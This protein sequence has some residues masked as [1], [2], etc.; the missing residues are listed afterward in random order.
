MSLS[1]E[2][3]IE[4]SEQY[5]FHK[6]SLNK[7]EQNPWVK[8][9]WPLVYFI[10][11]ESKRIAYVGESTNASSRIKNHLANPKK[12]TVF[13]KIS[14][15][16]SD[17]FNKSA[18]LDIESN[19][20]QYITSEGTYELQNGNYGLINHNYY[21]QD[22]YKDLFKEIWNK[23]I[24]KKIVSKSLTEIENSELFKYSPYKSLN[25]DQYKSV[26]EILEGL[27][28]KKTNR[29]FIKGSAGTGKTILAT[30]LIKLLSTD[31]SDTN[32]EEFN[33]NELKEI[34]Y[35][36]AF[37]EKYPKAKIGLVIAMT[38]LRK[39]LENVFRKIPGL[40]PSMVINPSDTFKLKEKYD[41]LIVD[42]AHR[43]RQ[44]KN[45]GWLGAF[46]KN[47]QK[48]GLDNTGN[49]LDWIMA[50]SK[51][52]IFFYDAAQ[53]VKPSDIDEDNFTQLLD[54]NNTLS[55]QLISQM[56]VKGGNDFISFVDE[57][58]H[59]RRSSKVLYNPK[60]YELLIFD[61][62]KDLYEEL[63][64]REEKYGLCRLIAGYS[65][66]WL[67]DPKRKPKPNLDAIDIEIDGLKF[68]W[69]KTNEDW[70]NSPNAFKQVGC[71]HT[72]QGYDLNYA[73]II[74]G[75][76][77]TFNKK[78]NSIEINPDL[79]FDKNGKRGITDIEDLKSYIINIY[80]TIMY[81]GIKGVFIYACNP[82]LR[83]YLKQHVLTFE[84]APQL[85]VLKFDDVIPYV[86]AVPLY[87]ISVAAGGFSE[88]QVTTEIKWVE[89]PPK[90]AAKEGYFV[91]K[92]VGESMNK[93]IP[94]NSF[95]LFEKYTGGSRDGKIVLV[96]HYKIQDSDFGAGYTVKSYHSEKQITEESWGHS[97][98]VLKPM[99][100]NPEYENIIINADEESELKTIGV[101]VGVL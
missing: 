83:E 21:Q 96:E 2:L 39:S 44:Y 1:F 33:D 3:S 80:K 68:Q 53:S 63:G 9:Q 86:N 64:K 59:V 17:K 81:R 61:S 35:I 45:I 84:K 85:R 47:N 25:E 54:N 23:L 49:E 40:K 71:I 67:S 60:N 4:I 34:I 16:G 99:S 76:E 31:I 7:I 97:S 48:L 92:V 24:E 29:I 66:E 52:Q 62:L 57:L 5:D 20:I 14:I 94:N 28:V 15:I 65:W 90:Y 69:N 32:L 91:C 43:L 11:N 30:Y 100:D 51:N 74:F 50:N 95:C 37:Q 72:T 55:L 93:K 6:D 58:M 82:E 36:K 78:T 77:I 56:R 73:G 18:T 22:L 101:F 12:S 42:E 10:Q 26:L 70:I 87:D 89:L 46:K 13:N 27:T 38:S 75:N 8:N 41:L 79:Y 98:I 88:L 19:L